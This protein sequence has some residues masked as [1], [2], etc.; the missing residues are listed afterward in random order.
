MM[1]N[2]FAEG[3]ACAIVASVVLSGCG[4]S[5]Y[6]R[7]VA[8]HRFEQAELEKLQGQY[9]RWAALENK[10]R[11]E[12]LSGKEPNSQLTPD[13]IDEWVGAFVSIS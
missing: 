5:G 10:R 11:R 9:E 7:A 2:R 6:R 13:E 1:S 12:E 8:A 4:G 3:I